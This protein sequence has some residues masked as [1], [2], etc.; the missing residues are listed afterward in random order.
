MTEFSAVSN[1]IKVVEHQFSGPG[2][3]V[4]LANLA[5]ILNQFIDLTIN[6]IILYFYKL[7]H[8][9]SSAC[10]LH[11]M[12]ENIP[13]WGT[14]HKQEVS[15]SDGMGDFASGRMVTNTNPEWWIIMARLFSS[16][17]LQGVI[18]DL[19]SLCDF[20]SMITY[21]WQNAFVW[22]KKHKPENW[23]YAFELSKRTDSK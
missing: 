12:A 11:D 13:W 5:P 1:P 10:C 22:W 23:N 7:F 18:W 14:P 2:G 15:L 19:S 16:E 21:G 4:S 3:Q 9:L 20:I 8:N 17:K 6:K